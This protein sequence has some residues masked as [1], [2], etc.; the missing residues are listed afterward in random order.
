MSQTASRKDFIA[1]E[2]RMMVA[3]E[4]GWEKWRLAF[5]GD[6]REALAGGHPGARCPGA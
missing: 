3:F 4:L 2:D 1:V 5:A 6:G